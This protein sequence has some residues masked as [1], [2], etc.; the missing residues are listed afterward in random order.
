VSHANTGKLA[1]ETE[2]TIGLVLEK[3]AQEE[4]RHYTFYRTIFKEVLKRDPEPRAVL[5][6]ARHAA[7]DMP[8]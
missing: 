5:R 4:A 6:V 8:A 3:V 2:P 1:S 7:I